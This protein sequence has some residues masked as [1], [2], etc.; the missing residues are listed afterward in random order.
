MSSMSLEVIEGRLILTPGRFT[1]L[2]D[3]NF[4]PSKTLHNK[5]SDSFLSTLK[6]IKPL[7]TEILDPGLTL[8]IRSL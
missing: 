6:F 3:P 7:S 5:V 1:C 8:S 2:L 4:P